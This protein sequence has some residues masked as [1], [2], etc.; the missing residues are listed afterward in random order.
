M[1]T[2]SIYQPLQPYVN[3][4]SGLVRYRELPPAP[5]LR[6]Y[7]ACYWRLQSTESLEQPF[8][9]LAVADACIDV[10]IET[11]DVEQGFLIGMQAQFTNFDLGRRFDYLGIRFLPTAFTQLYNVAACELSNRSF[12]LAE[13]APELALFL[14]QHLQDESSDGQIQTLLDAY[15][16]HLLAGLQPE[17]DP[18]FAEALALVM[19]A[20]NELKF[21]RG[22]GTGFSARQLRRWFEHYVGDSAKTLNRIVRFQRILEQTPNVEHLRR[23][24]NYLELGYYDQAHFC[25]EF[26]QLYGL[27]PRQAFLED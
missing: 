25:K 5:S 23:E 2:A 8:Q 17:L 24:K 26:K 10:L 21:E 1:K 22:L 16:T 14:A 18:R 11:S 4:G 6:P 19:G 20:E 12:G 7:L 13:V 3:A 9:Y 27:S 15:F